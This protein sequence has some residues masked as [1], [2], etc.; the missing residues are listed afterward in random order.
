GITHKAHGQ[1]LECKQRYFAF[2][3]NQ[4][5]TTFCQG[6]SR[7]GTQTQRFALSVFASAKT[8]RKRHFAKAKVG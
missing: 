1:P 3:K 4:T 2:G 6:K 7:V 5:N 8:R